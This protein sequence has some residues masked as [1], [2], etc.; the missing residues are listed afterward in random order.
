MS[1]TVGGK[2]FDLMSEAIAESAG[3]GEKVMSGSKTIHTPKEFKMMKNP[4]FGFGKKSPSKSGFEIAEEVFQSHNGQVDFETFWKEFSPSQPGMRTSEARSIHADLSKQNWRFMRNGSAKKFNYKVIGQNDRVLYDGYSFEKASDLMMKS[5]APVRML[6]DDVEISKRRPAG[7][8]RRNGMTASRHMPD[9]SKRD[10]YSVN[11]GN[12]SYHTEDLADAKRKFKSWCKTGDCTLHHGRQL[13]DSNFEQPAPKPLGLFLH[14]PGYRP[15]VKKNGSGFT[16]THK[17]ILKDYI[18]AGGNA[19]DFDDLPS[20]IRSKLKAAGY[21]ETLESDAERFLWDNN[22]PHLKRSKLW[23]NPRKIDQEVLSKYKS[24]KRNGSRK[25]SVVVGRVGKVYDGFDRSEALEA[26]DT[27]VKFSKSSKGLALGQPV[28]MLCNGNRVKKYARKV[29]KFTPTTRRL[30]KNGSSRPRYQLYVEN[31]GLVFDGVDESAANSDYNE[32]VRRSKLRSG[33]ESGSE[34]TM[35]K[36]GELFKS[37]S[38]KKIVRNGS[39]FFT[40]RKELVHKRNKDGFDFYF[41]ELD[42]NKEVVRVEKVTEK[43]FAESKIPYRHDDPDNKKWEKSYISKILDKKSGH[44][45][46]VFG[47]SLR[48]QFDLS[49]FYKNYRKE[50]GMEPP[51]FAV[52]SFAKGYK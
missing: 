26:F 10:A 33:R 12:K 35:L 21:P 3:T 32:Y 16:A 28:E 1:Y 39:D 44:S 34:V 36:D 6:R 41:I 50:H 49:E 11:C 30:T 27:Y 24:I 17:K 51:F 18:E 43:V 40:T 48:P 15:A 31:I 8:V 45:H 47:K 29:E 37:H 5:A 2:K 22:N 20:S 7:D 23:G 46:S 9:G 25:Y 52:L 38:G 13:L 42:E 14:A 19:C 4:L